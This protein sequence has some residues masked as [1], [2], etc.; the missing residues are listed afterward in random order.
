MSVVNQHKIIKHPDKFDRQIVEIAMNAVRTQEAAKRGLNRN[1]DYEFWAGEVGQDLIACHKSLYGADVLISLTLAAE[2]VGKTYR[3]VHVKI[4][5]SS[6]TPPA[7]AAFCQ[8]DTPQQPNY[9]KGFVTNR[10]R[11]WLKAHPDVIWKYSIME[12]RAMMIKE[13]GIPADADQL[14]REYVSYCLGELRPLAPR[15]YVSRVEV[16]RLAAVR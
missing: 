9:R 14:S 11:D 10:I 1:L 6:F 7:L 12:L 3:W 2:I 8:F 15:W 5:P 4:L 16:L 13:W